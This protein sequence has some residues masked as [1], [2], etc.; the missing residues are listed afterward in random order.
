[1]WSAQPAPTRSSPA[2]PS[3]PKKTALIITAAGADYYLA[4]KDNQPTLYAQAQ[5]KLDHPPAAWTSDTECAHGRIEYREP[6]VAAFDLDTSL[7]PGARQVALGYDRAIDGRI[8]DPCV[9]HALTFADSPGSRH[10]RMWVATASTIRPIPS[11]QF[12]Q[13]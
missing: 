7:F 1:M 13:L 9:S 10:S 2:T 5:Q 8:S 3:T 4:L 11:L 12:P 6:R